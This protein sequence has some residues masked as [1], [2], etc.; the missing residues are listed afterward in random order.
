M[1][2]FFRVSPGVT[3]KYRRMVRRADPKARPPP[4]ALSALRKDSSE[5]ALIAMLS[6]HCRD[7]GALHYPHQL[8]RDAER[9]SPPT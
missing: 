1:A 5:T 7:Y 3:T 6:Q 9:V 4:S 8:C 2:E